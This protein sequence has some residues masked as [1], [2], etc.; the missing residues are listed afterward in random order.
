MLNPLTRALS[1]AHLTGG[2]RPAPAAKADEAATDTDQQDDAKA[3]AEEGEDGDDESEEDM[4]ARHAAELKALKA[5]SAEGD[6]ED[7]NEEDDETDQE[8]R[9]EGDEEGGDDSDEEDMRRGSKA[10]APRLRERGRCA[11]IFQDAAAGRNPALAAQLAF[12]TSLPRSQAVKLLRAGGA[13]GTLAARMA[14]SAAPAIG[15]GAPARPGGPKAAANEVI[16]LYD[17]HPRRR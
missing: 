11:A 13:G 16:A 15:P 3:E 4:K 7:P 17:A 12:C 6:D 8:R 14:T 9:E 1:Y 5:K 10:S 2:R